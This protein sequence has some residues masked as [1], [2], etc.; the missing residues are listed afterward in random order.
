M[1]AWKELLLLLEGQTVHL[2]SPKNHYAKDICIQGDTPVV[3]TG[4][5][6]IT[7]T[8]RYNVTDE[9]ENEMMSVRWKLFKFTH[10]IHVADQ[11]EVPPFPTC[12]SKLTLMGEL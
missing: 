8:G 10:Q 4:K 6:E 3:A 2:P 11:K 9:V 5:S 12:F 7:Y 1:I